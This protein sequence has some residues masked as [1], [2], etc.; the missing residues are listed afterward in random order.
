MLQRARRHRRDRLGDHPAPAGLGGVG[1]PGRVHRPAGRL[2]DLQAALPRRQARG[3]AVRPQAL[4]APGRGARLRAHRRARVQPHVRDPRRAGARTPPRSP[5]CAPRP[6]RGSSSTSRTCSSS[7]AR[8]RRSGSRRSAS[9][10]ATRSRPGNFIFRTREFEQMEMEFFVPPDEAERWHEHW[11]DE[12]MRWYTDL[13]IRPDHL[14]LR[15][16][17]ADEL[18]HYS[19]RHLRHRVPVPDGLV[20]ARG[21]RQPRR[22]RPHPARR[23]L[24]ARSSSTSTSRPASATS[25]T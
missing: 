22:L 4:Q 5:T 13:G 1:A 9:R 12:R 24:A 14:I 17:D 23:V 11:I 21:H 6:P 18:S 20:G 2:Q 15:A 10:F 3:R 16:H 7:R 25:R 8:S 19:Q